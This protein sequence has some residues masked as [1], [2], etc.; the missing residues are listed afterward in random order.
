[1]DGDIIVRGDV[2]EL[3]G[4]AYEQPDAAVC[5]AK[6]VHRFE[7]PSV[8]VFNNWKCRIL[9]PDYINANQP[10]DLRWAESVSGIG[11]IP[12]EWNHC[13]GYEDHNE[14]A[15]LLHFTAGLP[16]WDETKDSPHAEKWLEELKHA[17]GTVSYKDL[18]GNSI[19]DPLVKT[20]QLRRG[21]VL[22]A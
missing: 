6:H 22:A 4:I 8:M 15:K 5:V 21:M 17:T 14:D 9:T 18:M 3:A 20:G 16:C 12:K 2:G 13:I 10:A 7:W 1:M 11:E 19:H